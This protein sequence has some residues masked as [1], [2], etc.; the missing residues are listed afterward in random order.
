MEGPR[1]IRPTRT[2]STNRLCARC[3]VI[4]FKAL[5]PSTRYGFSTG[6]KAQFY[7]SIGTNI[8]KSNSLL[9]RPDTS[10]WHFID[11]DIKTQQS[12]RWLQQYNIT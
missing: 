6:M 7:A 10:E 5:Q 8:E 1:A 9:I 12:A 11:E 4:I 3:K 2:R